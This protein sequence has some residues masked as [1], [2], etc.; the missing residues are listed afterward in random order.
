M[1]VE[2]RP[3]FPVTDEACREATGKDFATW[4]AEM[5]ARPEL[6]NKRRD[7]I[8]YIADQVGRSPGEYWWCTTIWVE[9]EARIG[10]VQKDGRPEGYN[11]CNTKSVKAPIADVMAAVL[12]VI[13]AERIVR[14]RENKDIRATWQ[15]E[16]CEHPSEIDATFVES[17]G[18]VAINVMVNRI[19]SRAES[20]GLRRAWSA[21]LA[22]IKS[23]LES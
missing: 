13:P 22:E 5:A 20:D 1:N 15:T 4:S 3:D 17:G 9:H 7:A 14:V 18:K 10:K 8:Q 19:Q 23:A 11:I 21:K 16:G 6:A 12:A 2:L